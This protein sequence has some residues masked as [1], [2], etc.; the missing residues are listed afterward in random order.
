MKTFQALLKAI[1]LRRNKKSEID[2]KP[3]L[4]LPERTTEVKHAIFSEDENA[5]YKALETKTQLQVNKYL[6]AGTFGKN[7][8]NILVLLLRLRQ[9]CCHPHLIKDHGVAGDGE[10]PAEEMEELARKLEETTVSRIKEAGGAF[11]CPVCYDAVENPTIFFPCGHDVCSECFARMTDPSQAVADGVDNVNAKCPECRGKVEPRRVLNYMTFKKVHMPEQ[12]EAD[13]G[14]SLVKVEGEDEGSGSDSD[15]ESEISEDDS[16]AD[17]QGDLRDFIVRDDEVEDVKAENDEV[18]VE[19]DEADQVDHAKKTKKSRRGKAKGKKKEPVKTLAVL[20][21]EAQRN[22][23]AKKRYLRRLRRDWVTSAKIE[24]TLEILRTI[25]D[26]DIREKTIIFSQFTSLLDLLE[27][28]MDVEG[29]NFR[30][31]DGSM[32]ANMRNDAVIDFMEKPEVKVMLV[33]LK[34]GNAGLNLTEASQ[35][36]SAWPLIQSSLS[37]LTIS[38]LSSI[39]SGIHM[40]RSRPSIVLIVL[41]SNARSEFIGS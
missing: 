38:R 9:A 41:G 31:Y 15:S 11:E 34:A 16:D 2:G 26:N 12:Y 30:R 28:P 25:R 20:K 17:S 13:T 39:L 32:S 10:V 27:V 21:K 24:K 1:L 37:I 6:K 40:S 4:T 22:M 23:K 19:A 14:E 29:W 36:V 5:F 3:I 35:V 18:A 7:Y 8:S 33:S